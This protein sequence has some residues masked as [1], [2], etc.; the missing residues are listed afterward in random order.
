MNSKDKSSSKNDNFRGKYA[1]YFKVG[2]NAYEFIIDFCQ[3]YPEND[4]DSETEKAELCERFI[5]SPA[6]AKSL[7]NVLMKS[8][9]E[10]EDTFGP[11]EEDENGSALI[12]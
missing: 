11:I 10:Y 1:N 6:Y 3:Y 2:F 4:C 8:I 12:K 9:K 5:T 7:M